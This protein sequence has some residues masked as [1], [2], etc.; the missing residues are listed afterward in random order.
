[1]RKKTIAAMRQLNAAFSACQRCRNCCRGRFTIMLTPRDQRTLKRKQQNICI[2]GRCDYLRPT[3]C[4]LTLRQRPLECVA[5]PFFPQLRN[6]LCFSVVTGT[7]CK[8]GR[9]IVRYPVL[10]RRMAAALRAEYIAAGL[11]FTI[12]SW[13]WYQR[14][15]ER[16]PN[17]AVG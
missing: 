7:W 16:K 1:M 9:S 6:G 4:S 14:W 3:G 17:V 11:D 15:R 12:G 8:A 10:A 13:S 5:F 2:R